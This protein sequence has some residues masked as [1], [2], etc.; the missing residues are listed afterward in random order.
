MVTMKTVAEAIGVS[1]AT[2]SYVLNGR[3]HEKGLNI[4]PKTVEKVKSTA[5]KLGYHRNEIARSVRTG[6]TNVFGLI[7]FPDSGYAMKIIRGIATTCENNNYLLKLLQLE[8]GG[9]VEVTAKQCIEQR[10]SGVIC[11]ALREEQLDILHQKL[12]GFAIP[13]VLVDNSFSHDW[14]SRV[15]SD[16]VAGGRMAVEYLLKL[17]HRKIANISS[18]LDIGFSFTRN[19]GYCQG[20]MAAGIEQSTGLTCIVDKYYDFSDT[21]A[22]KIKEL[23]QTEQ[24]TAL[25]CNSDPIAM[26]VLK[27]LFENNIRVPDDISVIG[28]GGL[29]YTNLLIP[30]L[31]TIKQPFDNMGK[32][33]AE[34]LINEVAN[35]GSIQE[36]KL[37]VELIIRDST[38]PVIDQ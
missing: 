6:K 2:V 38:A 8:H 22:V 25:F 3:H 30:A 10:L 19:K 35:N 5:L 33:A 18:S 16:D 7:G 36:V 32:K 34:V 28:Y 31:T 29:S 11:C 1:Q 4:N 14:S 20:L 26:K 17:G 12:Q 23:L 21:F 37:P 24:P 13:I 27:V 9:D 15:I